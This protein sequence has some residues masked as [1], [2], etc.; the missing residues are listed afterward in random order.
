MKIKFPNKN[1]L[2]YSAL[3]SA[4]LLG[5]ALQGLSLAKADA[6]LR[7]IQG[8]ESSAVAAFASVPTQDALFFLRE[9][10][11]KIGIFDASSD[12]LV[13]IIDV[14]AASLPAMDRKALENGIAIRS[15]SE[16]SALIE[17]LTT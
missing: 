8:D 9:C 13:D 4:A 11:G 5:C 17:D 2:L 16:L 14:Y 12:I 15:F 1:V 3:L 7:S 10:G 6:V